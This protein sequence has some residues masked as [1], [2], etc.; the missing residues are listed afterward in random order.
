[1]AT[2][3]GSAG[4]PGLPWPP[5]P[6]RPSLGLLPW[7]TKYTHRGVHSLL[8]VYGPCRRHSHSLAAWA[9]ATLLGSSL[10]LP[11]PACLPGPA[12]TQGP[13]VFL[14]PGSRQ[15]LSDPSNLSSP[16]T[17]QAHGHPLCKS[18]PLSTTLLVLPPAPRTLP[19]AE[20]SL[21]SVNLSAAPDTPPHRLL[22][23]PWSS[24]V[25]L[26]GGNCEVRGSPACCGLWPPLPA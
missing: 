25:P 14:P 9:L 18:S 8:Q 3:E 12:H 23:E 17:K 15:V 4:W 24:S 21:L 11:G 26:E 2:A 10:V 22:Q 13:A 20:P 16:T 19:V 6:A 5:P 1:M 7:D